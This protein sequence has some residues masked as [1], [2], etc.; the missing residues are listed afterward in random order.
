M[1]EPRQYAFSPLERR[2]VIAGL[3]V[4]QLLVL[5]GALVLGIGAMRSFPDARGVGL[6][7][8]LASAAGFASFVPVRGWTVDQWVPVAARH[9]ARVL[10]RAHHR[11]PA[12]SPHPER[13]RAVCGPPPVLA[14]LRFEAV[15]RPGSASVAIVRD[16]GAGTLTGVLAVSGRSFVLL[17]AADKER[18]LAGWA[19]VLAALARE[20]GPV[21]RIQWLER[22][23]PGDAEALTRHLRRA[24]TVSTGHPAYASYAQLI[25]EAGPLGQDHECFVA[26]TVRPPRHGRSS[27]GEAVLLRELR[28][29]EG[30]LHSAEIDVDHVLG[31]RELGALIRTAFDPWARGEIGRRAGIHPDLRGPRPQSVWPSATVE[32]WATWQTDGTWHATFW[33]A[34]WPRLD[35]GADFHGP[36]LLH[37][38]AQR[39]VALTMAPLPPSAGIREAESARTAQVA[40]EQLRQRAGFLTTARRRREAEGVVRREAELSDGHAAYR[41]TGYVAVTARSVEELDTACGEVVQAAH[42]CRIEL[43]RL[44]GAQQAAFACTLPFGRGLAGR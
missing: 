26:L 25:A 20:G 14:G 3:R 2:G 37:Q 17:D 23:V 5:G 16:R 9:G 33:V 29:L 10:T 43:R 34:E 11:T 1:A 36:L 35:V 30:Q 39:T 31:E 22:T 8:G 13:G 28:L 27:P 12:V 15:P 40:D 4:G 44:Y 18:R 38:A 19:A 41:Y 42:Q 24:G 7:I 6:F 21:R 32:S